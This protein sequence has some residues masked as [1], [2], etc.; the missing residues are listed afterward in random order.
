MEV[1]GA[2]RPRSIGR[3][4]AHHKEG[5]AQH[6]KDPTEHMGLG[7]RKKNQEKKKVNIRKGR[8]E[9]PIVLCPCPC[10]G[11]SGLDSSK[12]CCGP[13]LRP[14]RESFSI[15]LV[16]TFCDHALSP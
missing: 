7:F 14:V 11:A 3:G 13:A 9:R 8:A 1:L 4:I 2:Q 6:G 15:M 5:T 16:V 10:P 12:L